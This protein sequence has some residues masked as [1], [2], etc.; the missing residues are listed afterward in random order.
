MG[1][2]AS[3]YDGA[4]G[5]EETSERSSS[6]GFTLCKPDAQYSWK[7]DTISSQNHPCK[8]ELPYSFDSTFV[9]CRYVAS[10]SSTVSP[11]STSVSSCA[12]TASPSKYSAASQITSSPVPGSPKDHDDT[13][14]NLPRRPNLQ[15]PTNKNIYKTFI[16]HGCDLDEEDYPTYPNETTKKKDW[17]TRRYYC[18]GVIK[19]TNSNCP[20]AGSPPTSGKKLAEISEGVKNCPISTCDGYQQHVKCDAKCRIDTKLD[21]QEKEGWALLRH[22]GTHYHE[23][24][25]AKKANPISKDKLKER[26]INDT[27]TGPIGLKV[28]QAHC[29]C[30]MMDWSRKGLIVVSSSISGADAHISFQTPWMAEVLVEPD[31]RSD[32][33][34]GG[35]LSDITYRF[36][37]MGYLLTTSKYCETIKRWVPVLFTWLGGLEA[38]HYKI[39]FKNLLQQIQKTNMSEKSKNMMVEQV[40][41]FSLAQKVGF[42]EAY[43]EVFNCNNKN[44]ALSKLHGCE[45]HFLQAVTRIKKN[46]KIV[47]LKQVELR[48][49]FPLAK[50]W[51]E[52]WS[53]ADIQSMLFPAR[54]RKPLDDPPLPGEE[55]DDESDGPRRRADLPSTTNGQESMHRVYYILCGG[56]AYLVMVNVRLYRV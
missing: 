23:W 22:Q 13:L 51:I 4:F 54:K 21:A 24:P 11:T 48:R 33:Y 52:W 12:I 20:L 45:W 8:E 43:M 32:T 34:T 18:L 38:L 36:F 49:L 14:A 10:S 35:L 41:D 37:K 47:K 5:N 39:H 30:T 16:D 55:S 19:C 9:N 50:K 44:T 27:K 15:L 42:Q 26:V 53:A 40:V 56:Y 28:G 3:H 25:E 7:E 2:S 6:P 29:L 17:I 31:D 46:H 1:H